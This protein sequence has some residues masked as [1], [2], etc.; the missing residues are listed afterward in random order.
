MSISFEKS[1]VNFV[2]AKP[3]TSRF[4]APWDTSGWYYIYPNFALGSKLYSNSGVTVASIDEKYIGA[5]YVVTFNSAADG[6]DDKQEVDFFA[7]RDINVFVAFD[8]KNVPEYAS[9]WNATGDVMT[10]S[11]GTEYDIYSKMFEEG[12][13]VNVPGFKGESNHFSVFVLPVSYEAG[14]VPVPEAVVSPRLPDPYVKRTY[15]NYIT[16]VFNA[17]AVAPE[18]IL[19]GEVEYCTREEEARDGFVKL[20]GDSHIMRDFKASDRVV[21]SAKI[22]VDADSRATFSLRAEDGSVICKFSFENERIVSLGAQVGEYKAGEDISFRIVYNGVKGRVKVYVNCR[23]T[24]TIGCGTGKVFRVRYTSK[25]GSVY[26][27]NLVVSDDTELYVVDD[28]FKKSPDRFMANS[29]NAEVTREAYPYKD[30]NA[31]KVASKDEN[32]AVMS[33]GFASVSGVCSVESLLVANS[34]E[35]CLAPSL[36]DKNGTP[37]MRVALYENNLYASNGD[38]FVRIFGGLCEFHYFPCQNAINI[39][40]TVDT[41]K[42]TY[43]LMV[44]GAYRAKGFKLMNPVS[45]VSNAVYSAGKAGLTLMRIRV[46]D[47]VDFTRGMIPNA[48]VFDVTKAPYNAI[49]DGKTLETAKIQK[50]IDDAEFTGGTVL[51]PRGT[52]FTGELFLKNDMTLWVDR[53]ATILGTHDHGEYPL[54]EPG[55]SLCAVRQLGRGLVY[56][57]NIQNVRVTGGG[58]LDGNGTYRFKMNDPISV[59]RTEDCRPDLCY[60]T[61]SKDIVIENINFKSP[62]FWTVVPLSSRNIIMHHLNLDC[63]NTPNRDGIDPVD[64][65]DM[66]IYSCNIMAGDDG[67]CFK[68]SDPYGCENIDVYDMMIQSLASGIKFG[69]DT[70]YSL[71]NTRVRDCFV[72]NVNRCGVSLETVD[73]ADIEN[74]VF[75]RI[76]MTDVGAPVYITVGDRKRCPR[77]GMEPRLGHIDGVTFSELRFEHYYPFSHTKH[78]REVMAIGQYDHAR[79][80]NVTF[81]DCYFVLPGG[82]ETIPGEPKTIDNR[83][84]E[85]DRHGASTGH[86]FTVKYAKN[87]TVENCEIKLENPDVRPQIAFYE[88]GK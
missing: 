88:Y 80:D 50:A 10:S 32:L 59:R 26:L 34:E 23:K 2:P 43:D 65:H 61:Y 18:Y 4:V 15:K 74:V 75:E 48:P 39:K 63:L 12:A 9:E 60:I 79:I 30:S 54:M 78:V 82:A 17:G 1:S 22:R 77:G 55:T 51:L 42:G 14:N 64:C 40:V 28:D 47:D 24:M 38:E 44:D 49:G 16:D 71:K 86:A 11:D 29:A 58:M 46:Y 67:L 35:F 53:D 13:H 68:S 52:F 57:E 66:T 56:G 41:D 3:L 20:S 37:A 84:P 81:K 21:A 19:S 25:Y 83:Y 5:D 31:F 72:K 87:F 76:S 73:G 7:E 6:F 85:Y 27:D 36:T 33:Y 45:E 62:G 70:Y 8:K 69:T